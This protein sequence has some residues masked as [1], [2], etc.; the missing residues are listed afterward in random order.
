M[1]FDIGP[2]LRCARASAAIAPFIACA[3]FYLPTLSGGLLSDDYSVLGA[4]AAWQQE[5]RLVSALAAKFHSGLDAPSHYYRPLPI[6]SFAVNYVLAGADAFAWR[7]TN[8]VLHLLAGLAVLAIAQRLGNPV[9]IDKPLLVPSLAATVFLWFPTSV[10]A[11]AWVSGR[12]DLLATLLMLITV[13]CFQRSRRWFDAWGVAALIAAV[14]AFA[15]KESAALLPVFVLAI[16]IAQRC[17]EGAAAALGRGTLA[18]APWLILGAG[19]FVMRTMLFGSPFRVYPGTTPLAALLRGDWLQ[20]LASSGG[21]LEAALPV[22]RAHVA[23]LAALGGLVGRG[24]VVSI[25]RQ[26]VRASWLAIGVVALLSVVLLLPHLSELAPDGEGGR[27]FYTTAALLALLVAVSCSLAG[28]DPNRARVV[29]GLLALG[30]VTAEAILLRA[31]IAPWSD[32]GMQAAALLKALPVAAQTIP[33]G[34]YGI[35]VVPDRLGSV[36]FGRNAQGGLISLPAQSVPL[37]TLLIVQ[38]P[39]DLPA[40]PSHIA[41]GLVDALRRYP[42]TQAWPA[43]EAGRAQPGIVPSHAYCWDATHLAIVPVHPSRPAAPADW[44]AAWKDALVRGPCRDVALE[45]GPS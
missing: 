6:A 30:L 32:A 7:L 13:L 44:Y 21:W 25:R 37:S 12:Y 23:F 17:R 10:E 39:V 18:A 19:Y 42:L 43:V 16:A 34:G 35:V 29:V 8:L 38:T 3:V 4:L 41:R 31:A 33:E 28:H 1:R 26:D 9:E 22:S 15:S 27:L 20:T 40:W 5:G 36:P 24:A 11:V 14:C 45:L 2:L